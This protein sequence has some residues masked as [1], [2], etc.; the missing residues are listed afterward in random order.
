MKQTLMLMFFC[1]MSLCT[2][3]EDVKGTAYMRDGGVVEGIVIPKKLVDGNVDMQTDSGVIRLPMNEMQRLVT[4]S[5]GYKTDLSFGT[6]V[7][8]YQNGEN[9]AMQYYKGGLAS[10]WFVSGVTLIL[11]PV[12]GGVCSLVTSNIQ[13]STSNLGCPDFQ[14]LKNKDYERGYRAQAYKMKKE[15]IWNSFSESGVTWLGGMLFVIGGCNGWY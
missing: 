4:D 11:T 12:V 6:K 3:A 7:D 5:A 1:L 13:P 10:G 15:R 2:L 8:M 9:D 14:V